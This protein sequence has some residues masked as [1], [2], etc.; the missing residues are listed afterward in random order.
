M[1]FLLPLLLT[2]CTS[3]TP[4]PAQPEAEAPSVAEV[5]LQGDAL[6]NAR[7]RVE[8]VEA[9]S[10]E[11]EVRVP[12]RIA[13][14]PRQEARVAA[15]TG[16]TVERI[17]VRPG[18]AVTAGA[19]LAVVLS[20]DLGEAIGAHLSA[21]ARLETARAKRERIGA[22]VG[23]GFA[24]RS[25]QLDAD[26]ELTVAAADAEAAEERL[27]VFGVSPES[28]RPEKGQHF[29]S[30][31][32]VRSPITGSV[33]SFD[34]SLGASVSSGDPLFHVGNLDEV[35]LIV[36]VYERDL[37][38]VRKGAAVS[39]TVDAYGDERFSGVV[40]AIGDWLD[41]DSRTT[42]VRVVVSNADHRLKP[43]MFA[44]ARL[45]VG[46]PGVTGLS[47]PVEAI[48]TIAG[49]ASVFVETAPGQFIV[50]P[51]QTAPVAGGRLHVLS[52]LEPG[53]RVVVEG[54]FTLTSELGKSALEGE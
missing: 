36:E 31:V 35:W 20:P 47:I 40:D 25:Q 3:A 29:S 53:A 38:S 18:D 16:G 12:A 15:V 4:A 27:R 32:S 30:R 2:A 45:S 17:Q 11:G 37:A 14:D 50:T 19:S 23:D 43:N 54:A 1:I 6:T 13:L 5:T 21:T 22:L 42:E 39:F 7:L 9:R 51:V 49:Q 41:P 52:G 33:L 46:D 34:A 44:Q 10:L 26:A 48:Q 28:V 24:S 8:V